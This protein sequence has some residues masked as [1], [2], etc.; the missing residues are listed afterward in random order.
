MM[1]DETM[2]P[3][4]IQNPGPGL[5]TLRDNPRLHIVRP[6]PVPPP[7]LTVL[8]D[9]R[10][11][12]TV[13]TVQTDVNSVTRM[14]IGRTLDSY[15]IR[16]KENFGDEM[17]RVD[18]KIAPTTAALTAHTTSIYPTLDANM[19]RPTRRSR[20]EPKCSARSLKR[21][22]INTLR[23]DPAR[24]GQQFAEI[25]QEARGVGAVDDPV[26]AGQVERE[27]FYRHERL[28]VPLRF[29]PRAGDPEDRQFGRVDDRGEGLA[30]DTAEG[31][32]RH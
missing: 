4:D 14:M 20:R 9:G 2:P 11:Q 30:A 5:K 1:R 22:R 28:A 8:R 12:G 6:A 27:L 17:L 25:T 31:G 15:F 10:L 16:A 13:A 32:D 23:Q 19:R 29:D 21:R 24:I 26:I 18:G 3:R 7:R